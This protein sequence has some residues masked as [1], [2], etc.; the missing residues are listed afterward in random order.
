MEGCGGR[1]RVRVRVAGQGARLQLG[2]REC[3]TGGFLAVACRPPAKIVTAS[4]LTRVSAVETAVGM[5][6][7]RRCSFTVA[8]ERRPECPMR[9][10]PALRGG[11]R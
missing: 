8:A 6:A 3:A 4:G 5:G 11:V 2:V 10:P 9:I 1:Y 7:I